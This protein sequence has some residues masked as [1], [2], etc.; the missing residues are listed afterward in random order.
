MWVS[1]SMFSGGVSSLELKFSWEARVLQ[2][3]ACAG[4]LPHSVASLHPQILGESKGCSRLIPKQLNFPKHSNN[5]F[6]DSNC[7]VW[8]S[9]FHAE[10]RVQHSSRWEGAEEAVAIQVAELSP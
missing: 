5:F 3:R 1:A 7:D 8:F 2:G 10:E 4:R 9:F 6:G